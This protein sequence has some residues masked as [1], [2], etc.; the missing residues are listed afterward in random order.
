MPASCT[1]HCWESLH[2]GLIRSL[3]FRPFF[4]IEYPNLFLCLPQTYQI[5][6]HFV[7]CFLAYILFS[8]IAHPRGQTLI[9]PEF[10]EFLSESNYFLSVK[11]TS[12]L[13]FEDRSSWE[14]FWSNTGFQLMMSL[15]GRP[16]PEG[17]SS[18][19]PPFIS[20]G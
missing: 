5:Y 3:D 10:L 1:P 2:C 12:G 8:K 6:P 19:Q 16:W 13:L 20:P 17:Q 18:W 7:Y 4:F 14:V 11:L 15:E 9:C